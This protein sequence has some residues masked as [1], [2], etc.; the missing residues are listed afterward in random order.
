MRDV[1]KYD[2]FC[3][4]STGSMIACALADG[5][6][7]AEIRELYNKNAKKIFGKG[8]RNWFNRIYRMIKHLDPSVAKYDIYSFERIVEGVFGRPKV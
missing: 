5:I 1:D 8:L 6:K 4:V 2:V 7:P 3:G